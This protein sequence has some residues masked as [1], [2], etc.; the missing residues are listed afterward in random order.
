MP[1][2]FYNIMFTTHTKEPGGVKILVVDP[3]L[4]GNFASRLSHSC[5][6]NC[7]TL[8]VVANGKYVIGLYATK[9]I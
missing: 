1:I 4:W 8:P 2:D 6:P 7:C 3:T 5:E 9:D